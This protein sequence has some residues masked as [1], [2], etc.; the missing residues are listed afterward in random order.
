ME[1]SLTKP[2]TTKPQVRVPENNIYIYIYFKFN[3]FFFHRAVLPVSTNPWT[4]K[5]NFKSSKRWGLLLDFL[6]QKNSLCLK[7]L[8]F[9]TDAVWKT[10]LFSTNNPFLCRCHF[11]Y[12]CGCTVSHNTFQTYRKLVRWA[13]YTKHLEIRVAMSFIHFFLQTWQAK[14]GWRVWWCSI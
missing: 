1:K 12:I 2:R 6:F 9:I 11:H 4:G 14:K 10:G 8:V 5:W 13:L 7:Y 3:I